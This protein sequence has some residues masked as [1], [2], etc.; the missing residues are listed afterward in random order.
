MSISHGKGISRKE[1][2]NDC[3][4]YDNIPKFDGKVSD[5][6]FLDQLYLVEEIFD[7][8]DTP[9]HMKVILVVIK[10]RKHALVW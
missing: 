3:N 2:F 6:K 5:E 7:Y 10:L 1:Q 9:K 4:P 8:F